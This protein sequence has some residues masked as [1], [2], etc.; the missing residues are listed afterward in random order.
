MQCL[1]VSG[2]VRPIYG[3]LGVERLTDAY[4]TAD[5]ATCEVASCRPVAALVRIRSQVSACEFL[6]TQK[7]TGAGFSV[8]SLFSPFS[9]F[10]LSA[11]VAIKSEQLRAKFTITRFSVS[12]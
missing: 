3:S 8:R 5:D 1:E 4:P 10:N 11:T 12:C 2:A 6:S 7:G 9:V